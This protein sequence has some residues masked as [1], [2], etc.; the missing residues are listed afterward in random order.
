MNWGIAILNVALVL[1]LSPLYEGV[2]RKL[3]ARIHSRM[4][5]PIIQ[6]Y[7]DLLKLLGKEELRSSASFY[8][9]L[10]PPLCLAAVLV[11]ALL[12][13]MGGGTPLK[14]FSGD[15]IVFL[16][17][18]S[19]SAVAIII[20]AFASG[21]PYAS[22]GGSREMMMLLTVEPVMWIALI[23]AVVKSGTLRFDEMVA[24]YATNGWA[25][26]LALAGVVFLA[27]LQAQLGKLPFDIPEA[28]QEIMEGPFMEYSGPSLALYRWSFFARGLFLASVLA[29]VFIPWAHFAHLAVW[30]NVLINLGWVLVLMLLVGL[31]DSVVPRLRI[32]QSMNWF[33]RVACVGIVALLLAVGG[34]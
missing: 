21:S 10:A 1:L 33:A 2:I 20:G 15:I 13:P 5:P 29:Q 27:A 28:D 19:L 25:V 26:S 22:V 30:L 24:H 6:P 17:V 7:L 8:F 14:G 18:S 16:C 23:T 3:K 32:D 4:G 11:T 12:A 34:L 9:R 31:V